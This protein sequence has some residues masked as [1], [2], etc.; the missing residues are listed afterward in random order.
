[1]A[2][3]DKR[4]VFYPRGKGLIAIFKKT[5][6]KSFNYDQI[7]SVQGKKGWL[8][9]EISLATKER[10]IRFKNMLKDDVDQ[11][12]TMI[13][14]RKDIAKTE[15]ILAPTRESAL[16]QLKKLAELRQMGAITEAEFQEK[17]KKLLEAI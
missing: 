15:A 9:G 13:S 5:N 3:T 4:I 6:A 16:D 10:I 8:M 11:I 2:L 14:R 7:I 1:M 17:R 12:A